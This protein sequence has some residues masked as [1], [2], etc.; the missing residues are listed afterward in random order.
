[1]LMNK[2]LT[3][4]LILTCML[5]LKC[6]TNVA[7]VYEYEP[8]DDVVLRV[9]LRKLVAKPQHKSVFLHFD[10]EFENN[11]SKP[12]YIH[13]GEL[14]GSLNNKMSTGTYYDSLASVET[15][16]TILKQ[17]RSDHR[18]YFVFPQ[19]VGTAEVRNFKIV[20]YGIGRK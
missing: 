14:Q 16:R 3:I 5:S 11:A 9:K 20:N 12:I 2:A 6:T 15:E 13:L 8:T 17:G 7:Q 10:I 19:E 1:M 18:L 4:L